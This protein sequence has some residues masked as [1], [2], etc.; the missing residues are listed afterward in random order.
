MLVARPVLGFLVAV[1]LLGG[2]A[3]GVP[4]NGGDCNAR[5]RYERVTYRPHNTLNETAPLGAKLGT[6]DVVGCGDGASAPKVDEVTV[7]AVKNVPH[8]IAVKTRK[9]DWAGTYVA[10]GVPPS[11]WPTALRR[12]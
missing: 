2:C 12:P 7:Y 3:S 5:I 6:G 1:Q 11:E 9:G 8:S 4:G 10:E